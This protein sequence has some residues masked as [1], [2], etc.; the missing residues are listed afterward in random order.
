M[1]AW[2][3]FFWGTV[4]CGRIILCSHYFF[5][6]SFFS[7]PWNFRRLKM[8]PPHTSCMVLMDIKP[9]LIQD[10]KRFQQWMST[11]MKYKERCLSD[12]LHFIIEGEVNFAASFLFNCTLINWLSYVIRTSFLFTQL[13]LMLKHLLNLGEWWLQVRI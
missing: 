8:F 2:N 5:W 9:T 4:S 13:N 10:V 3:K 12:E 6:C 1:T 11:S 7:L